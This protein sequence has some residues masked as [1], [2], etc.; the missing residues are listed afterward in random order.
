[1]LVLLGGFWQAICNGWW[2]FFGHC[3]SSSVRPEHQAALLLQLNHHAQ[4]PVTVHA[5]WSGGLVGC[6]KVQCWLCSLVLVWLGGFWQAVCTLVASGKICL[7]PKTG[8]NEVDPLI[9]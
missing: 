3:S 4:S 8:S 7:L 5:A 6:C 2:L 9:L 1:V